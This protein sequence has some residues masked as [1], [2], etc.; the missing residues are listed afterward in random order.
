MKVPTFAA[1]VLSLGVLAGTAAAQNANGA[2]TTSGSAQNGAAGTVSGGST[3][4]AGGSTTGST[5]NDTTNSGANAGAGSAQ[6]AD[7]R[8]SQSPGFAGGDNRSTS[9][10][11]SGDTSSGK[12][13][14]PGYL[15]GP[16]WSDTFNSDYG[17][18]QTSHGMSGY[19]SR[20]QT[21][22]RGDQIRQ[23]NGNCRRLGPT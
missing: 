9:S 17:A 8:S 7:G 5:Q 6:S 3:S 11:R 14:N 15:T 12:E 21:P 16:V 23:A 22:C 13:D 19:G 20:M 18:P 1:A 2:G 10:T 4:T